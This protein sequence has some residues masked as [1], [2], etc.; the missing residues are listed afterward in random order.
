MR[1]SDQTDGRI[2]GHVQVKVASQVV[3]VPVQ[4]LPLAEVGLEGGFFAE[5]S[6]AFGI[7]VDSSAPEAE[8]RRVIESASVE[9]ARF[10]SRK[11]LN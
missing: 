3:S 10:F 8:Q 2:V 4:A 9:A 6:D 11:F 7:R 1:V 5:S